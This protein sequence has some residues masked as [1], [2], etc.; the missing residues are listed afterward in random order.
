MKIFAIFL[1]KNEI[2]IIEDVLEHALNWADK[3]F[4]VDNGSDDGTWEFINAFESDKIVIWGRILI[5]YQQGLR[6]NVWESVRHEAKEGDWWCVMDSDEFYYDDPKEFLKNI[7]DKYGTICT[8]TIE[9]VPLV[10]QKKEFEELDKF[11][12]NIYQSYIPL[13]WS[14]T[15]FFRE[16]KKLICKDQITKIPKN[17]RATYPKR[18]RVLHYPLRTAK[19]IQ[20]RLDTRNKAIKNGCKSFT[21]IKETSWLEKLYS[22][23]DKNLLSLNE[24]GFKWKETAANF[25]PNN[26]KF[27]IRRWGKIF[28][29]YLKLI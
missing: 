21:H 18:I 1:V 19:Q 13:D 20:R 28:M 29:Y 17:N 16:T 9:F 15:R 22:E 25:N 8:N 27:I 23:D 14:E 10:S 2:D 4:L 7:P 12:K 26:I 3:I 24:Y 6:T 11:N 5:N